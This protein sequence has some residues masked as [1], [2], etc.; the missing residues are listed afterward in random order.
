MSHNLSFASGEAEM[1]FYGD[2]PWHGL[3][4]QV[5]HVL[6]AEEALDAAYLNWQVEKKQIYFQDSNGIFTEAKG[7]AVVRTDCEIPLGIVGRK[8]V[9][10]QN[11]EAFDFMDELV[12]TKEAKYH[13]AGAINDGARVWI[14]AK[15][16]GSIAVMDKDNVDKYLLVVNNHD[17]RGCLKGLLTPIRVV[18]QNTLNLAL[19]RAQTSVNIAHLGNINNKKFEAQR[20]LGIAMTHFKE[21]EEAYKNFASHQLTNT[22]LKKYIKEVIPGDSKIVQNMRNKVE[23]LHEVGVGAEMTRGTLWGAYNAVTEYIDHF[24]IQNYEKNPDRYLEYVNFG[25][26]AYMKTRA[27]EEATK[28]ILN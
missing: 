25:S 9:P 15:L 12:M 2:R 11:K 7:F 18:C 4:T 8:Y 16:P 6:T 17:G 28:L 14:L 27:F 5:D 21:L 20:V 3:G 13:T 24:R 23:E 1:F 19:M 26:G 22:D 10:I